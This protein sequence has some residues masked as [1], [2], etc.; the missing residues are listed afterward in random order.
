MFNVK[1]VNEVFEIIEKVFKGYQLECETIEI[2]YAV[3]RIC[4]ETLVST[5]DIP[6]FNRSS[7]DGY[8]VMASDTF[9]SGDSCP[10]QLKL[11][12]EIK[13]G[14]EA[15]VH[16]SKG[17]AIYVPTGGQIPHNADAVVM[18]EY[19]DNFDDGF[20]YIN[21]SVAPGNNLVFKGDD[22]KSGSAVIKPG[23]RIRP[24]DIGVLA[25]LGVT[26]ISVKRLVRVGIISTGDEIVDIKNKPEGSEVRDI[27]S[28]FLHAG[29]MEYGCEPVMYGICEDDFDKIK[30]K[31]DLALKEC[32]IVL[33]S[34][35]SSV[36]LK[37]Q[38]M[39]VINSLGLPGVLVHGI[40][41]KPGKPTI[42]GKIG[43]KAVVGLPGHPAAA[44]IVFKVFVLKII[45]ALS[46][47]E[48]KGSSVIRAKMAHNY[49]SNNGREEFVTVRM[50][51]SHDGFLAHPLFGKSGL[52]SLVSQADGFI[53][54]GRECEGIEEGKEVEVILL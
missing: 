25:A 43:D 42:L 33:I 28:Y 53:R 37:D 52:I 10:A 12:G 48:A 4:V 20:I 5:E 47:S 21:K 1:S 18:I 31:V 34:G 7:V 49:P 15:D 38:T 3:G 19:T 36:G 39:E 35:G 45:D 8:A 27:N 30:C 16:L 46:D 29:I 13:M 2:N 54:I 32:D 11:A 23:A 41:V 6:G 24:Q 17:E 50:E 9:G 26:H 22:I 40:A 44:Y 14:E 51:A